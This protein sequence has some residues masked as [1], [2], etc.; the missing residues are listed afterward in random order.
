MKNLL[1]IIFIGMTSFL[2]SSCESVT[3]TILP[4]PDLS[5]LEDE[6]EIYR[7]YEDVDN[8]TLEVM[9]ANGLGAR[10]LNSSQTMLCQ[11]AVVNV[12]KQ[13]KKIIVDFGTGC[14]SE[15][16]VVRKGKVLLTYSGSLLFPGSTII[17]S[18]EGYEVDG[19]KLEGTRLL[20]NTGI[21]LATST[22]TMT[23]KVENGK[24]TWPDNT[25]AT[26]KMDQVREIT[27][28]TGGYEASVT[29]TGSGKSRGDYNYSTLITNPLKLTQTCISSGIWVPNSGVM[30]FTYKGI[31]ASVDYGSGSCDKMGK[32]TYPG[33]SKDITFD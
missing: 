9:Q 26:L 21:N 33:G 25:F 30:Q 3:D 27:L 23:V 24:I 28:G 17:T 4:E 19:L 31:D 5:L 20:T 29:G 8:I 16:G 14:T 6:V 7:S 22:I 18:F 11:S 2:I 32:V 1:T 10:V 15:D 12:D 13:T